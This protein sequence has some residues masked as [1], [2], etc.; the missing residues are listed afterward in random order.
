MFAKSNIGD[1]FMCCYDSLINTK[2]QRLS[3]VLVLF[4]SI[5]FFAILIYD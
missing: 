5:Y 1:F 4:K 3:S 2:Y